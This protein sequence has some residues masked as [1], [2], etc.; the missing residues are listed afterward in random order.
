MSESAQQ[1]SQS[2]QILQFTL[3]DQQ[4]GVAID[5]I[6]EIVRFQ[7]ITPIPNAP[8][9]VLGVMD[10]RGTATTIIDPT[11]IL[12][13]DHGGDPAYVMVLAEVGDTETPVG[14]A[15]DG[16]KRVLDVH[17]EELEPSPT[18][19]EAVD[20]I[21]QQEAGYMIC[22]NPEAVVAGEGTIDEEKLQTEAA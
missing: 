4:Y 1:Q 11:E 14:W 9:H 3:D 18:E 16:V 8:E 12:N 7:E 2:W 20:G 17:S 21:V 6:M 22:L 15:V 5:Y 10:L 19:Q 13:I